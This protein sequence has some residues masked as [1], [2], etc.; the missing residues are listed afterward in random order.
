MKIFKFTAH[1]AS[2]NRCAVMVLTN[3][4]LQ[5]PGLFAIPHHEDG[6]GDSDTRLWVETKVQLMSVPIVTSYF[7]KNKEGSPQG[8]GE[9]LWLS[10]Q[11]C[12]ASD[13]VHTWCRPVFRF[14]A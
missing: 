13:G 5:T 8:V 14:Y 1:A 3:R 10:P 11:C 6:L 4:C 9:P 12:C 2:K 7:T